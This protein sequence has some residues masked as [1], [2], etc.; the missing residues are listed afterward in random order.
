MAVKS[1]KFG[2]FY[3]RWVQDTSSPLECSSGLGLYQSFPRGA[4]LAHSEISGDS[5]LKMKC[6]TLW[7]HQQVYNPQTMEDEIMMVSGMPLRIGKKGWIWIILLL[8]VLG[9]KYSSKWALLTIWLG[10]DRSCHCAKLLAALI[11]AFFNIQD[12]PAKIQNTDVLKYV[13]IFKKQRIKWLTKFQSFLIKC[14]SC[15]QLD[16]VVKEVSLTKSLNCWD[17]CLCQCFVQ[18]IV[19]SPRLRWWPLICLQEWS[20]FRFWVRSD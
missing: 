7:W 12:V 3:S 20:S 2:L 10:F 16:E 14:I 4:W 15:L 1:W 19:M 6:S 8:V 11:K 18:A 17:L 13:T 5:E 9:S